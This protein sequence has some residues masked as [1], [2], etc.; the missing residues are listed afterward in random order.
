ML[1]KRWYNLQRQ[2]N[3]GINYHIGILYRFGTFNDSFAKG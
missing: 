2:E 3:N 1:I